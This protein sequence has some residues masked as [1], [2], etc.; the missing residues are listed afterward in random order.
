[1]SEAAMPL[2]SSFHP[3]TSAVPVPRQL[4]PTVGPA[5]KSIPFSGEALRGTE[6]LAIGQ[7]HTLPGGGRIVDDS[8]WIEEADFLE[9]GSMLIFGQIDVFVG[10]IR[11]SGAGREQ[12]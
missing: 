4:A 2:I 3:E 12:Y 11:S 1:M 7:I 8:G 6:N 9:T 5:A 10:V